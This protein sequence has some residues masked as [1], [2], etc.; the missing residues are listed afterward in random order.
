MSMSGSTVKLVLKATVTNATTATGTPTITWA[1][2][3]TPQDAAG[4]S[5]STTGRPE[6][7][8]ADLDF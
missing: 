8:T 3:A 7:G 5:A 1:P 4:N 2:S 6:T